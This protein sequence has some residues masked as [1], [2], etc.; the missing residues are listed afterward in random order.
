MRL[1]LYNIRYAAGGG[2][3]FHLPIP[4]IGYLRRTHGNLRKLTRFLFDLDPDVVGLVEVDMGS[5]RTGS[6][7]NQAEVVAA[8]L[9]HD[10]VHECKYHEGSVQRWLPILKNQGNAI[11]TRHDIEHGHFHFFSHGVKRLIIELAT[12][13][14]RLFLV[15]LSL[16]YRTRQRQLRF[17][18]TLVN[19]SDRPVLVAGDFNTFFGEAEL[20][21]FLSGS[22]LY[23]AN[24]RS[25][26]THPS[27]A[28]KRELDF[29]FHDDR[30]KVEDFF[31]P[32]VQFSDHL[33]LVLDF[34]LKEQARG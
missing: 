16:G 2:R 19:E 11:I 31:I 1:V 7:R 12:Q 18:Q 33:P 9:G 30:V 29:I 3:N 17:L 24:M 14:F 13:E 21:A 28:P 34:S 4:G 10:H 15:H 6:R 25:E 32:E 27:H 8:A 5:Y 23:S 22:G 26:P 20:Y